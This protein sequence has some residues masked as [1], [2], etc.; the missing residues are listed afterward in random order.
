MTVEQFGEIG[1]KHGKIVLVSIIQMTLLE[2]LVSVNGSATSGSCLSAL[3]KLK[4]L[5]FWVG[6]RV[7]AFKCLNLSSIAC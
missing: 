3:M 6:Q 5:I 4:M 7:G 2:I 1:L